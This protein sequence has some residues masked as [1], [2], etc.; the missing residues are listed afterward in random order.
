M[1]KDSLGDKKQNEEKPNDLSRMSLFLWWVRIIMI[2]LVVILFVVSYAYELP[3]NSY[4]E[5]PIE[6]KEFNR[7]RALNE[8]CYVDVKQVIPAYE[9]S[10]GEY[11]NTVAGMSTPYDM[12]DGVY[13]FAQCNQGYVYIFVPYIR[14]TEFEREL[15]KQIYY[16][17]YGQ[18]SEFDENVTLDVGMLVDGFKAGKDILNIKKDIADEMNNQRIIHVDMDKQ[19]VI[20]EKDGLALGG[21]MIIIMVLLLVC[22]II[23]SILIKRISKMETLLKYVIMIKYKI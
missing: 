5:I 8:Y 20:Y 11:R 17:I 12:G 1:K 9:K 16:R 21:Y 22:I 19:T 13:Y 2:F 10:I 15:E 18:I 14:T 4:K 7:N 23:L 3:I 6:Y